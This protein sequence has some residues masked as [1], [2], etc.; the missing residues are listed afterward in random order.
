M[1]T[2]TTSPYGGGLA[3]TGTNG[4]TGAMIAVGVLLIV[5]GGLMLVIRR[6]PILEK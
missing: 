5:S 4:N 6:K 3:Y 2:T 1:I